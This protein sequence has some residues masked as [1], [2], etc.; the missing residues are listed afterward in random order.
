M[1]AAANAAGYLFAHNLLPLS[2][3]NAQADAQHSHRTAK[4]EP[5]RRLEPKTVLS[6]AQPEPLKQVRKPRIEYRKRRYFPR[7]SSAEGICNSAEAIVT[8]AGTA[9]AQ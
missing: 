7:P 3:P 9:D 8:T 1:S 4:P 5:S 6:Q 2:D